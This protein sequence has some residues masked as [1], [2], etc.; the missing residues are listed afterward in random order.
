MKLEK[1]EMQSRQSPPD[2]ALN[3]KGPPAQTRDSFFNF[4]APAAGLYPKL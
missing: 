1:P 4:F 3:N 2:F